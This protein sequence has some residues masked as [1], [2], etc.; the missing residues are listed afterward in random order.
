MIDEL[1]A[2][3]PVHPNC[4]VPRTKILTPSGYKPIERLLRGGYVISDDGAAHQITAVYKTF[5]SGEIVRLNKGAW[6]TPAHPFYSDG[7]FAA[8]QSLD[9]GDHLTAVRGDIANGLFCNFIPDNGPSERFEEGSFI[10]VVGNLFFSGSVPVAA[11]Y[12]N[13]DFY[14]GERDVDV[15]FSYCEAGDWTV[16]Q[17]Q[18]FLK[19]HGF[20][21]TVQFALPSGSPALKVNRLAFHAFNRFMGGFG[22]RLPST[23]HIP[24]ISLAHGRGRNSDRAEPVVDSHT[25]NTEYF[26]DSVDRQAVFFK[27]SFKPFKV[28]VFFDT[29]KKI[30]SKSQSQ[31]KGYVYNLTVSDTNTYIANGYVVHNCDCELRP[32]LKSDAELR[33]TFKTL[34]GE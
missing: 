13:G 26:G 2:E 6:S 23:R 11:V 21:Q 1:P 31:Y 14:I 28:N 5:Y 18:D 7:V 17:T 30:I 20:I 9:K 19:K 10:V 16:A 4:F 22:V 12:F 33:E 24:V 8:A 27:K 25:V 32:R 29:H 3:I 34:V 15:V